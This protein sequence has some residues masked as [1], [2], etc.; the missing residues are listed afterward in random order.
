MRCFARQPPAFILSM[1]L[2]MEAW[3][4]QHWAATLA[5]RT[6]SAHAYSCS[7]FFAMLGHQCANCQPW[8]T[9]AGP[10]Q[11]LAPKGL[12]HHPARHPWQLTTLAVHTG[13]D[14][15]YFCSL[16]FL[17][18]RAYEDWNALEGISH[19]DKKRADCPWCDF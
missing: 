14:H 7:A 15:K 13:H 16:F 6:Q 9:S 12:P 4:P 3:P 19:V 2:N 1:Q 5:A 8:A 11:L 18:L 10:H 17:C